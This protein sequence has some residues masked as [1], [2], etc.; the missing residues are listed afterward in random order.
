[1]SRV[2]PWSS[3]RPV[4]LLRTILVTDSVQ[5]VE[6]SLHSSSV[7]SIETTS[8]LRNPALNWASSWLICPFSRSAASPPKA[9]PNGLAI[10]SSTV[11]PCSRSTEGLT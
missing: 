10:T 11:N 8:L 2:T 6:P 5:T 7:S 1:M 4:R 3:T 9:S